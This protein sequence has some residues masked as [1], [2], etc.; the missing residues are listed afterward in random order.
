MQAKPEDAL[1]QMLEKAV[2][3]EMLC[4]CAMRYQITGRV[5]QTLV[6]TTWQNIKPGSRFVVAGANNPFGQVTEDGRLI[7]APHLGD[8]L[9]D[10]YGVNV[11]SDY[12]AN[13]GTAQLFHRGLTEYFDRHD[14]NVADQVF[15][16]PGFTRFIY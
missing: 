9:F 8:E 10:H 3:A 15:P 16:R 12:V 13:S 2:D 5:I 4:P 11:V 1:C 6:N 14:E 7:E